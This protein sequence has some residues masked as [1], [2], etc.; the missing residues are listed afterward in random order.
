[1]EIESMFVC[2]QPKL[3]NVEAGR[4]YP[5]EWNKVPY[6][7]K[8]IDFLSGYVDVLAVVVMS[9]DS[10]IGQSAL[11]TSS[12]NH[13]GKHGRLKVEKIDRKQENAAENIVHC[14]LDV[15]HRGL[16]RM[17]YMIPRDFA[18]DFEIV[19]LCYIHSH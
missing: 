8:K 19:L 16:S 6:C 5:G 10:L 9:G 1:M 17:S 13:V 11:A 12:R 18:M 7:K 2:S 4:R 3:I 14:R 15:V